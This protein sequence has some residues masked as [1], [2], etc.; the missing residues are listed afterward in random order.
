MQILNHIYILQPAPHSLHFNH[1][2]EATFGEKITYLRPQSKQ[3]K[4]KHSDCFYSIFSFRD[5]IDAYSSM[6]I[7]ITFRWKWDI[8]RKWMSEWAK[9]SYALCACRMNE[10]NICMLLRLLRLQSISTVSHIPMSGK[11]APQR[12][13][14]CKSF[15]TVFFWYCISYRLAWFSF[16][17]IVAWTHSTHTK[18][19][20]KNWCGAN[21]K[22]EEWERI[23]ILI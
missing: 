17:S 12:T 1:F 11:G 18:C 22:F 9:W 7:E 13:G 8:E 6:V 19:V 23:I 14:G 16:R 5:Y 20:H 15:T 3:A 2:D 21:G 4:Y 10:N